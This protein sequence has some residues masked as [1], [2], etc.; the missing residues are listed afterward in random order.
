MSP[1]SQE[2]LQGLNVKQLHDL[3][4]QW[5]RAVSG[6][7]KG[8]DEDR[9]ARANVATVERTLAQRKAPVPRL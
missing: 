9:E 5:Q 1:I 4:Q 7:A 8:S 3:K 2:H 6:C